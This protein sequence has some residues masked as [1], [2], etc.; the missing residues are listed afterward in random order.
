M[1]LS[2][3]MALIQVKLNNGKTLN[4]IIPAYLFL[5]LQYCY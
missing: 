3:Q 5:I 1:S 2:K 4:I